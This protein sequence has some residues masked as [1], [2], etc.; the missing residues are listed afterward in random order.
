M[1]NVSKSENTMG[2]QNFLH[3]FIMRHTYV[4]TM[5]FLGFHVSLLMII[6]GKEAT[7]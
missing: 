5:L 6:A 3:G 4:G 7:L 1:L 2:W